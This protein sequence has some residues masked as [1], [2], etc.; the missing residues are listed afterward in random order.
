MGFPVLFRSSG[1][2][3][4]TITATGFADADSFGAV[5][6]NGQLAA[7]GVAS[8][9]A[10]GAPGVNGTIGA[11]PVQSEEALGEPGVQARLDAAGIDNVSA[12]GTVALNGVLALLGIASTEVVG[13]VALGGTIAPAALDESDAFGQPAVGSQPHEISAAGVASTE[14][15]GAAALNGSIAPAGF[16][17]YGG[18]GQP[19]V[20]QQPQ[21]QPQPTFGVGISRR[22][23]RHTALLIEA[24]G[25]ASEEACGTLC[26]GTAGAPYHLS[27]DEQVVLR[28]ALLR[29]VK[30]EAT[31][32]ALASV[33]AIGARGPGDTGAVGTAAVVPARGAGDLSEDDLLLLLAA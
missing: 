2:S 4:H 27:V 9:E 14:A 28:K 26:L 20:A 8:I 12:L 15:A 10:L 23:E 22:R 3:S 30:I 6:L 29:S 11:A 25:I 7:A 5:A 19:G 32:P 18:L 31:A 13:A 17:D 33:H 24:R 16:Y 21:A 1:A